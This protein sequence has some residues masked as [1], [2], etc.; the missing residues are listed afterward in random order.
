MPHT[1]TGTVS[2]GVHGMNQT[3]TTTWTMSV[4]GGGGHAP[5]SMEDH[6]PTTTGT[7]SEEGGGWPYYHRGPCPQYHRNSV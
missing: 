7:V 3:P 6:A 1:T 4:G 2:D 5:T